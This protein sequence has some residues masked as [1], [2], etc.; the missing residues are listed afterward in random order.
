MVIVTTCAEPVEVLMGDISF[1][2]TGGGG[3]FDSFAQTTDAVE[4]EVE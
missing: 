3:Q 4:P 2:A 1:P